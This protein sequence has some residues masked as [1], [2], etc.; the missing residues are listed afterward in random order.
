MLLIA[1]P[2]ISSAQSSRAGAWETSFSVIFQESADFDGQGGSSL[3]VNSDTGFGFTFAL[4]INPKLS[5]GMDLEYLQPRYS[6][7][8]VDDTGVGDDIVIDHKFTQ[9]NTR[10]KGTWNM[11]DG[12]FT[13]YIEAGFG[14]S[15]FD[16]NVT[17]GPPQTGCYWTPWGYFCD[18]YYNTY[19][20]YVFSYGAGVGLRYEFRGGAFLKGSY[21]YWDLDGISATNGAALTSGK[22]EIGFMF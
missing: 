11:I 15:Y 20:D 17:N 2:T 10:F 1:L 8:L 19:N 3:D 21:N 16:T 14:W 13:P 12:P 18:S 7:T 6:A 22:L 5:V 9:W 4:N